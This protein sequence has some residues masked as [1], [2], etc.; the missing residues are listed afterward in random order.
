M[1]KKGSF[2]IKNLDKMIRTIKDPEFFG[3]PLRK[4][5]L[6][7]AEFAVG[8]T[9]ERSPVD[10]G[11]LRN[12]Y[13]TEID[14]S[15][16]PKFVTFGTNLT[17][18]P[19]VEEGSKPHFPPLAALQPWARRHGFPAGSA[20][21]FLVARAIAQRGTK[22]H[23]MLAEGLAATAGFWHDSFERAGREIEKKWGRIK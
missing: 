17:Y 3:G 22:G 1:A 19:H 8:Q 7:S 10:T 6:Q 20:G 18:A 2:T 15:P 12:S 13:A 14:R 11:R 23:H 21:A 4:S 5:L 16:I 9:K